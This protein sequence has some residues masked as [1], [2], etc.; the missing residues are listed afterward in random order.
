MQA[1]TI[2]ANITYVNETKVQGTGDTG[3]ADPWRPV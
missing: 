2:D 1:G 3:V